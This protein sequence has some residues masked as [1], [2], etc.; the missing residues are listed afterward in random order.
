MFRTMETKW[1]VWIRAVTASVAV[2][3]ILV[4]ALSMSP[5]INHRILPEHPAVASVADVGP[6]DDGAAKHAGDTKCH[7]GHSC[8]LAIMPSNESTL[9][10]FE[11]APDFRR[12][13]SYLSSAAEYLLFH[14]PRILSQV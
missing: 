14:P 11:R 5:E 8:I 6:A 3:A 10:H 9:T 1:V 7:I 2:L 13:I 12:A 4:S